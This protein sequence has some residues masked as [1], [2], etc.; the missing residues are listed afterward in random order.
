MMMMMMMMMGGMWGAVGARRAG[1]RGRA[2]R[3][4]SGVQSG[5]GPHALVVQSHP[6]RGDG[7]L[8][9]LHIRLRGQ[10]TCT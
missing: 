1:G 4:S 10:H 2:G 6:M 3:G 5:G 8:A 9:R 7:P